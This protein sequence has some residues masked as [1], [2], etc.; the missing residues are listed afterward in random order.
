[1]AK[2]VLALAIALIV[3]VPMA[4]FAETVAPGAPPTA[5]DEDDGWGVAVGVGA[6]TGMVAMAVITATLI[7]R[8]AMAAFG[9]GGLAL[10]GAVAGGMA[11]NWIYDHFDP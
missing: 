3:V 5:F 6:A 1:M 9:V 10:L 11:G 7:G 2:F 8:T 4:G